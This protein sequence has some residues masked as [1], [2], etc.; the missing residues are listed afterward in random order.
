MTTSRP[1]ETL[2]RVGLFRSLTPDEITRL[3]ARC[4]FR[5][6]HAK[7]WIIDYQDESTDVF[8][9]ISG[10]ARVMIRAIS[11]RETILREIDGGAFFGEF[12]AIDGRPRSASILAVTDVTIAKMSAA[13]FLETVTQH[14]D[15]CLQ[16]LRLIT[17]QVRML[18]NRVNEFT[19]LAIRERLIME[20]LR[21]SR[22]NPADPEQAI[23][24]PP[25]LHA[26]LAGRISTRRETVTKELSAMEREGL[27]RRGR[28]AL[29]LV[30]MPRLMG[31]IRAA[32]EAEDFGA[33]SKLK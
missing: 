26:D 17:G 14:A 8:F 24:S 22:A 15:V 23:V 33:A 11:G 32:E 30:D 4:I 20:L 31:A 21:L 25:P 16:L 18:S 29:T 5:R 12:S 10:S 7:D 6:A 19:T 28:R 27:V 1:P 9:L 2:A 13:V 3:N